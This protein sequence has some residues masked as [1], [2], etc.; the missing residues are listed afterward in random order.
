MFS[1]DLVRD[2]SSPQTRKYSREIS[3][4]DRGSNR[5]D[6]VPSNNRDKSYQDSD[7]NRKRVRLQN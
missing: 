3:S 1:C 7:K 5:P 4:G 2:D 6:D